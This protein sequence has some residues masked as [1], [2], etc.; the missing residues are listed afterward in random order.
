[1]KRVMIVLVLISMVCG[2][3]ATRIALA[4]SP[5]SNRPDPALAAGSGIH[6]IKHVIVIMQENRSFDSYF[7][8]F[9]GADGIPRANGVPTV[10]APDATS[11]QCVKPF[12]DRLDM[13]QGGPHSMIA[14]EADV[15]GGKMDGFIAEQHSVSRRSCTGPTDP[16]C[17]AGAGITQPDVMGYHTGADIPNYWSYAK[18]FVLQDHMFEPVSSWSWPS[19]LYMVSGWSAECADSNPASCKNDPA[20]AKNLV[21]SPTK[22]IYAWTDITYLLSKRHV[23]WGYYVPG[24]VGSTC[25]T[26][27]CKPTAMN[28]SAPAI[29]NILPHFTT[30]QKDGQLGKIRD[31]SLFYRALKNNRLPA[32]SWVAPN[33]WYSEHPP[34]LVSVGQSY[35]TKLIDAVMRSKEWSSTAIFLAWDDWGGFYDNVVPPQVDQNGYGLRVPGIVISP[36]ARRHYIDHQT[37]SFDAYLKFIEDDFLAGQRLNPRTDGRPDPRPDVRESL[38]ALGNVYKD[39]NFKLR[40]ARPLILPVH[41]I[42]D[43]IPPTAAQLAQLEQRHAG[44]K[45][46]GLCRPRAPRGF[47]V[48]AIQGS[49][50]LVHKRQGPQLTVTTTEATTFHGPGLRSASFS[51]IGVGM[52]IIV[53]GP[54]SGTVISAT[55][56]RILPASCSLKTT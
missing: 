9:P 20:L 14:D 26:N 37:L 31:T 18:H 27:F 15:N 22:S 16:N 10:C 55:H 50:L 3:V 41:P 39:F 34:N 30:V 19:H 4:G 38:S 46:A 25:R 47:F 35:V 23:S 7:G 56:I 28:A 8:T 40:P 45:K 44:K 52:R 48:A 24:G 21:T 49:S 5:Y 32:V 6:K 2:G 42:T 43:L 53:R 12:H 13:N 17:D 36:Y 11:G 1:M 54:R 33:G 29:W 51:S